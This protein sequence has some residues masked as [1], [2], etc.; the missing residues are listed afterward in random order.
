MGEFY[1]GNAAERVDF[2]NFEA[3]SFEIG[4]TRRRHPGTR[5]LSREDARQPFCITVE[6]RL[7]A[8]VK[9]MLA[10]VRDEKIVLAFHELFELFRATKP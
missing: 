1:V 9:L 8:L 4:C 5:G 10:G 3:N 6:R 2:S 7:P